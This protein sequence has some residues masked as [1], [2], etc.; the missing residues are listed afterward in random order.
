MLAAAFRFSFLPL[1]CFLLC[2]LPSMGLLTTP[3]NDG[4]AAM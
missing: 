1:V 4:K 3:T 2:F